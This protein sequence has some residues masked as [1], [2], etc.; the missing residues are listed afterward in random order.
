LKLQVEV[1]PTAKI[2]ASSRVAYVLAVNF[3][4]SL[5]RFK[6]IKKRNWLHEI[7]VGCTNFNSVIIVV[8]W[9]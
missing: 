6:H 2:K 5:K 9:I 1:I 7:R 8:G 4:I 3:S